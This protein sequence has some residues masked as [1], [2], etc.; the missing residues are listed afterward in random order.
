MITRILKFIIVATLTGAFS[1]SCSDDIA[2]CPSRMC[3]V[4]GGWQLTEAIVDDEQYNGDLSQFRLTLTYPSPA[5][6]TT[7][8]FARVQTSGETDEGSW[9]LE[10][11][12]SVLRLVPQN[13]QTLREDWI[14]SSMTPRKMVLVITRDIDIKEGPGK[15]EL[16]LEPF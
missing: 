14:I 2:E 8:S 13:N 4:A 9:S 15:I 11:N 3:I 12:E 16:I 10:N 1:T 6:A 5:V 7:S